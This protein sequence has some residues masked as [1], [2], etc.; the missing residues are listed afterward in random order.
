MLSSCQCL[1]GITSQRILMIII[2]Q[3]SLLNLFQMQMPLDNFEVTR[4]PSVSCLTDLNGVPA[5][6][7]ERCETLLVL[8]LGPSIMPQHYVPPNWMECFQG[9]LNTYTHTHIYIKS[10][11]TFWRKDDDYGRRFQMENYCL[12]PF[13][14]SLMVACRALQTL[15]SLALQFCLPTFLFHAHTFQLYQTAGSSLIY[16]LLFYTSESWHMLILLPGVLSPSFCLE[17]MSPWY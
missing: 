13:S 7:R 5:F 4:G 12:K 16:F 14:V 10:W 17:R 15:P 9:S 2:N 1:L 11:K 8:A 6:S 3:R